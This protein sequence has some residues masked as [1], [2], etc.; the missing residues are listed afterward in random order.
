LSELYSFHISNSGPG[1][2]LVTLFF[3][4]VALVAAQRNLKSE[5][6]LKIA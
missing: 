2:G 4:S 3:S 6:I 1:P 5:N